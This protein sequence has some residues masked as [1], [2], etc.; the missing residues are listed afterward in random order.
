MHGWRRAGSN[1]TVLHHHSEA[2]LSKALTRNEA[3]PEGKF[4]LHVEWTVKIDAVEWLK[5]AGRDS[6]PVRRR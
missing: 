1:G 4:G 6:F 2:K 3:V 5:D